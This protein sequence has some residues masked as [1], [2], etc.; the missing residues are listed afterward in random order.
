[1]DM[2]D[3]L[4][5]TAAGGGGGGLPADTKYA[6]SI[7]L[8]IDPSTFIITAQLKDQNGDNIGDSQTID[9]PFE[10]V[11]V[12]GSYDDSTKKVILTLQNGD[13]VEFSVA[14]LV[15]GLQTEITS[16]NKLLSDLVDDTNQNNKFVTG[17]SGFVVGNNFFELPNGERMY[18]S[19]TEPTGVIPDG[20]YGIGF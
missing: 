18:L 2:F 20:S 11:V 5:A 14:D 8:T 9:L 19:T 10:S 7:S 12:G 6:A 16:D 1:M 4:L 15:S 3:I 17:V 13:T